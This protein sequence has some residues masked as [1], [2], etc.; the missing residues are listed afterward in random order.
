MRGRR[1]AY[2]RTDRTSSDETR[3]NKETI[4]KATHS[5]KSYCSAF[6]FPFSHPSGAPSYFFV[7]SFYFSF[8]IFL[9]KYI[10]FQ[11]ILSSVI[12]D[13]NE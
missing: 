5:S 2:S 8:F 7:L 1:H 11:T 13:G 6:Y 3:E 4:D 10:S 9:K 12:I